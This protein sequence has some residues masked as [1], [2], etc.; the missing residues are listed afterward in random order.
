M[1]E[2]DY[3][4]ERGKGI[5]S[6]PPPNIDKMTTEQIKDRVTMLEDMFAHLYGEG[7]DNE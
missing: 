4:I 6:F 2:R 5:S 3:W 1:N 7:E